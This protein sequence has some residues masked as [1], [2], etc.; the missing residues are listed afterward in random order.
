MKVIVPGVLESTEEKLPN[1]S[2]IVRS[3]MIRGTREQAVID[4]LM[5]PVDISLFND[6]SFVIYTHADWDHCWGSL[7]LNNAKVVGH[8]LTREALLA[9]A[10]QEK[11]S[12]LTG[13]M[14]E[15]F[16]GA[17]IVPPTITFTDTLTIDLGGLNIRLSH[18][19][20][21]TRDSIAVH[22]L[23]HN[24]MLVGDALEDP[25]PYIN[26]PGYVTNWI[27]SLRAWRTSGATS[28][29]CSHSQRTFSLQDVAKTADYL[30][31][32]CNDVAALL[33]VGTPHVE[34]NKLLPVTKYLPY[35]EL[36]Q[37]THA[38]NL[39]QVLGSE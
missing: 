6:A 39:K 35:S 9:S 15:F 37:S 36:A 17:A 7:G 27:K 12:K 2:L 24:I 34:I 10:A 1:S 26:E 16:R 25:I 18:C 30:E 20:G 32:L 11:L 23:E 14:P 4:S 28:F 31:E 33:R 29:L 3:F 21:H 19:P 8:V 38:A 13:T 5:R 22:L